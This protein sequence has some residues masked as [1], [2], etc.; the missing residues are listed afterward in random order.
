MIAGARPSSRPLALL[1][2]LVVLTAACASAG[3]PAG[4]AFVPAVAPVTGAQL[5]SLDAG[6]L[7]DA[8][9]RLRPDYLR[10]RGAS[11]R[12]PNGR[13]PSVFLNGAPHGDVGVLATIPTRLVAEVR[14]VRPPEARQRFGSEHTG[15]II[16][17]T[18]RR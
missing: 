15:G 13:P 6:S 9:R 12:E 5:D 17:V 16:L 1:A 11:L 4:P 3:G 7:L 14:L 10:T 18:T 8:L 2:A